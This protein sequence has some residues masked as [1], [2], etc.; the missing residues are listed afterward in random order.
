MNRTDYI[1]AGKICWNSHSSHILMFMTGRLKPNVKMTSSNGTIF[2]VTCPLCGEFTGPGEFPAQRPATRSFDV[3]FDL[4]MN[5][6]LSK[7]PLDL[8]FERPPWSLWRHC[9]VLSHL[10]VAWQ[11]FQ[12]YIMCSCYADS[13]TSKG[14]LSIKFSLKIQMRTLF[15]GIPRSM[16]EIILNCRYRCM[17]KY[18]KSGCATLNHQI[19][20]IFLAKSSE[21]YRHSYGLTLVLVTWG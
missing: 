20:I 14:R 1:D 11:H 10:T 9:N 21:I 12:R 17:I 5:K 18:F 16:T 4:L 13:G 15:Q 19:Y 8:W 2:R 6:R 3:F 7:Q